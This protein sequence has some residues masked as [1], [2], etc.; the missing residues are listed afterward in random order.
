MWL[1]GSGVALLEPTQASKSNI[2]QQ[3]AK[4]QP[5]IYSMVSIRHQ[6]FLFYLLYEL[7]EDKIVNSITFN[8]QCLMI[9]KKGEV[10]RYRSR[11]INLFALGNSQISPCILTY[12]KVKPLYHQT[13]SINTTNKVV[14][15]LRKKYEEEK[16]K[17]KIMHD[18][19]L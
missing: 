4:L 19:P 11:V 12:N 14:F 5:Y 17:F 1:K 9:Y 13:V 7:R 2:P 8:R 18:I 3:M 15:L 16:G 6:K 10:K